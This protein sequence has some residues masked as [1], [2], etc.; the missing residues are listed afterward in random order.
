MMPQSLLPVRMKCAAQWMK[1]LLFI[2]L[3][4]CPVFHLAA[5]PALAQAV[6]EYEIKAAFIYN[7]A[8]FV[9]WPREDAGNTG[10]ITI[11]VV[12]KDPF[13]EALDLLKE[14]TIG[15]RKIEVKRFTRVDDIAKCHILFVSASENHR[16]SHILKITEKWHALTVGDVTGFA[17]SGGIINFTVIGDKVRFEINVDAAHRAGLKISS[18]LLKLATI[19]R[20]G[21]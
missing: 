10:P 5:G 11:A 4:C 1:I 17:R 15:T 21:A 6:Q 19:V 8:K 13:G 9:E 12:G 16:L 7:F 14:K 2:F 18:Q 3:S 20:E